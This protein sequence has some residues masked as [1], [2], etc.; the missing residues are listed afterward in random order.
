M[1]P[2]RVRLSVLLQDSQVIP[3][4]AIG[5]DPKIFGASMDSRQ[6]EPGNL[7]VA[8][9][10]FQSDGEIFVLDAVRRGARAVVAE[11]ERP[12]ALDPKVGWVRV[13]EPRRAAGLL[14][15]ECYGRPDESTLR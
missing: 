2:R 7:F 3:L 9:R 6:V 1:T 14:A 4:G 10:G 5:A 8:V 12:D 15:R 11:S 13:R